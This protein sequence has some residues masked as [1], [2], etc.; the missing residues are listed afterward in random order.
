MMC[1]HTH[2]PISSSFFFHHLILRKYPYYKQMQWIEGRCQC[3]RFSWHWRSWPSVHVT[4]DLLMPEY[5][6]HFYCIKMCWSAYPTLWL[7]VL[8]IPSSLKATP[9]TQLLQV[10]WS[11]SQ[12]LLGLSC[13]PG[14]AFQR[15]VPI[16]FTHQNNIIYNHLHRS[17]IARSA[18]LPVKVIITILPWMVKYHCL[19]S[20]VPES[21]ILH[22][23]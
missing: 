16:Y 20:T 23:N 15:A 22:W 4:L 21:Y 7:M 5:A 3:N 10:L 2:D 9:V 19:T 8:L 14:A 18:L 13:I 6:Y 12:S 11:D 17:L 1:Q